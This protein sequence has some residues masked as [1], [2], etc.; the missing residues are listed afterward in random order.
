MHFNVT[1][2]CSELF[3]MRLRSPHSLY[4]PEFRVN[5]VVSIETRVA[6]DLK[7]SQSFLPSFFSR[8]IFSCDAPSRQTDWPGSFSS[9]PG[10][11]SRGI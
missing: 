5:T 10:G 6:N 8:G 11:Q 9:S 2:V 4:K 7:L 1:Q 3:R